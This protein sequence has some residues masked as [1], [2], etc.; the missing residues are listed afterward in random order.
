MLGVFALIL[1]IAAERT[2]SVW[3]VGSDSDSG[4]VVVLGSAELSALVIYRQ[5]PN[6]P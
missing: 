1:N 3:A 2:V 6:L 4:A 5:I